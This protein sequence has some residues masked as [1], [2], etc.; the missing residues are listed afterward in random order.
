MRVLVCGGRRFGWH[1]LEESWTEDQR[2]NEERNFVDRTLTEFHSVHPFSLL[3]QGGASGVDSIAQWWATERG[4]KTKT[5]F[6]N[7]N[8][9]KS[10]GPR[11]NARMLEE[12]K[13]DVVIAFPGGVGTADMVS[14][15]REAGVLV[16][17]VQYEVND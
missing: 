4:I 5:Y 1:E 16:L 14:K 11:R 13:P 7:W 9:G 3:M 2:K 10:A 12:G 15:A 6:A 8:E 17:E